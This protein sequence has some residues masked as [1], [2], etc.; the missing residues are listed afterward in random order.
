MEPVKKRPKRIGLINNRDLS[1]NT[2][3]WNKCPKSS[4]FF[5]QENEDR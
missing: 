3:N 1:K 5:V 2:F 4:K